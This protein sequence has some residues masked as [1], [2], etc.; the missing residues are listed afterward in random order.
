MAR[1]S[2]R[3]FAGFF[4]VLFLVTSSAVAV[5]AIY[6]ATQDNKSS[7]NTQN[8][9]SNQSR[10]TGTELPNFTPTST[11]LT[12]LQA[13]DT[14][15]GTGATVKAGDVVTVDYKGALMSNGKI[16]DAS[17][18]HGGASPISLSQVIAGWSQGVPGM[19]VGGTRR[20]L[21]PAALGYGSQSQTGIPANSD[22]VFD[23]TVKQIDKQ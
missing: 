20:L 14:K 9:Q 5:V 19:K 23:I 22:L 17:A 4:A 18:D 12:A 15:V 6:A 8:Q 2:E 7:S 1:K 3:F 21:I 11:P 16:F 13:T 10:L